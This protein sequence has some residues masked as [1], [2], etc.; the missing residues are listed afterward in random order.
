[1]KFINFKPFGDVPPVAGQATQEGQGSVERFGNGSS[2]YYYHV[3]VAS[4]ARQRLRFGELITLLRS[5][6]MDSCGD[7]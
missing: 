5:A 3:H 6:A 1:M 4:F 2:A 7:E